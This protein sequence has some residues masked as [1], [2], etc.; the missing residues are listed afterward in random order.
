[1]W[2]RTPNLKCLSIHSIW[3]SRNPLLFRGWELCRFGAFPD[4]NSIHPSRSFACGFSAK[5]TSGTPG[6]ISDSILV[7]W[8]RG[9][10]CPLSQ[11]QK[12]VSRATVSADDQAVAR[13]R[14]LRAD[15]SAF[16]PS[17]NVQRPSPRGTSASRSFLRHTASVSLACFARSFRRT[18][19][20]SDFAAPLDLEAFFSIFLPPFLTFLVFFGFGVGSASSSLESSSSAGFSSSSSSVAVAD[21]LYAAAAAS[22]INVFIFSPIVLKNQC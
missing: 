21:R 19:F 9:A 18:T 22:A 1:M 6:L 5:Y 4:F 15:F 10:T 13:P 8:P 12:L 20:L 7:N 11:F 14:A 3:S 17:S 16:D 2:T